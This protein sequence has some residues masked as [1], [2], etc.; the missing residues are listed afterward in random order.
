MGYYFVMSLRFNKYSASD[1][2]F[3]PSGE[4]KAINPYDNS[5]WI[6]TTLYD[7]G[8][9]KEN[10]FY[11][12]PIPSFDLLFELALYSTNSDDMYGAAA[13][14]LEKYPEELL[15]KCEKF[16]NDSVQKS[17]FRK[18]VE[19]FNLEL[20]TN[21]CS[22]VGKTFEQIQSDYIRWKFI[23]EMAIKSKST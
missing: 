8:W 7:F 9:G 14:I 19:L 5:V 3:I 11:K 2:G 6:K 12:E 21:R 18:L 23:S 4:N 1:F 15:A 10:G 16:L 20:P 22:L 13:I 17:E